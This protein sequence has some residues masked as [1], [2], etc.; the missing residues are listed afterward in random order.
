MWVT[1]TGV[2]H[3]HYDPEDQRS[4]LDGLLAMDT[5]T[6]TPHR[7]SPVMN[8]NAL[9]QGPAPGGS[10]SDQHPTVSHPRERDLERLMNSHDDR[11]QVLHVVALHTQVAERGKSRFPLEPPADTS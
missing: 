7:D 5:S 11:G 3:D 4:F 9:P 6:P 8:Q 1:K 10:G 2:S